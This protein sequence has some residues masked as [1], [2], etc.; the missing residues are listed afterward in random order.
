MAVDQR[1]TVI[2]HDAAV[3]VG[4]Q[5]LPKRLTL[6]GNIP[7]PFNPRTE[8]RYLLPGVSRVGITIYDARGRAVR[9]LFTGPQ[10]PGLQ[11]V[12]W[13]GTDDSGAALSSGIYVAHV[14][15]VYGNGTEKLTLL[16]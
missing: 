14:A 2:E 13:N 16:K 4:D 11:S 5:P 1:I 6:L 8:I 3:D 7:D 10:A 15:T 9:H 12:I